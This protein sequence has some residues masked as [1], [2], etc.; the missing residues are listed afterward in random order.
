M[1]VITWRGRWSNESV[2]IQCGV[3]A[4]VVEQTKRLVLRWSGQRNEWRMDRYLKR[5]I[6]VRWREGGG[7][8]DQEQSGRIK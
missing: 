6:A 5:P 7:A 8:E 3:G 2:S 1:H 4:G